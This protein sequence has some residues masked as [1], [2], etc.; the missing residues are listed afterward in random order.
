MIFSFNITD[1]RGVRIVFI[2]SLAALV[3]SG[4]ATCGRSPRTEEREMEKYGFAKEEKKRPAA[5]SVI[6]IRGFPLAIPLPWP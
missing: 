4:C 3:L 2:L 6:G 1:R 5:S